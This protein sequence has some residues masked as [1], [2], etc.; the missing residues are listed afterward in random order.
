MNDKDNFELDFGEKVE[1]I[2]SKAKTGEEKTEEEI[3][4]E[5]ESE[6]VIEDLVEYE[7]ISSSSSKEAKK[8]WW[9]RL[10]KWKKALLISALSLI[11]LIVGLYGYVRI[12]FNY[13]YD[14]KFNVQ[15]EQKDENIVNVALFG[16]DCRDEDDFTGLT[17]SIMILSIN[18]KTDTIKIISVMRDTFVPIIDEKEEFKKYGKINSA[19]ASGKED[20]TK[21][22]TIAVNTLN[23][24]YDLDISNYAVINFYGMAEIIDAVGGINATITQDELTIKGK[25]KPNLNGCM[26]E[27]CKEKG[28]NVKDYYI[29]KPGEQKLNGVQAVAYARV[30]H[31]R[32]VWGTNNDFGRTDRQRHVM[33]ELFNKAVKMDKKKY[34]E[35]VDAL[36]PCSKTS[37]GPSEI[38]DLAVKVLLQNPSFEQYRLPPEEHLAEMLM[39]S[40]SGYGSVIYYDIDY[41]A[42]LMNAVIFDNQTFEEF[43]K[44][45][46]VERNDWFKASSRPSGG[47]RPSSNANKPSQSETGKKPSQTVTSSKPSS[48]GETSKPK[49]SKDEETSKPSKDEETSK[50]SEEDV[51]SKPSKDDV[52]SKPSEDDV[53]SEETP[54]GETSTPSNGDENIPDDVTSKPSEGDVTSEKTPGG[55]TSTPSE[56]D[57]TSEPTQGTVSSQP[58]IGS[59]ETT[60]QS[61]SK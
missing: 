22:A 32:S 60:P 49:P 12:R 36:I 55:E 4:Q 3:S 35:L 24:V 44:E 45:N 46:P 19:Y 47:T 9:K 10:A 52:T 34:V 1:D 56:D 33:Q 17:D 50:P 23:Y 42:R 43:I 27:I 7:D 58:S 18:K 37:L 54:S 29:T 6:E 48:D 39:N 57:V 41:V 2:M 21:S 53:T 5:A 51:T 30:R 14:K 61:R 59:E 13:N 40:P 11:L 8:G 31:C 26:Q 16:V 20:V 28:L 25:D 38:V 15:V